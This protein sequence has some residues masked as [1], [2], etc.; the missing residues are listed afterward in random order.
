MFFEQDEEILR[1]MMMPA[2]MDRPGIVSFSVTST[3]TPR[4]A[5]PT[6]RKRTKAEA[7][8]RIESL[9]DFTLLGEAAYFAPTSKIGRIVARPLAI[10]SIA[11]AGAT[12]LI[13]LDP[14]NRLE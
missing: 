5:G 6:K 11:K 13:L 7:L 9:P 10:Y 2:P 14:L 8:K 12:G 4:Q 1:R 3:I